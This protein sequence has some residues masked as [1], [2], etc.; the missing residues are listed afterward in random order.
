MDQSE[1]SLTL[2]HVCIGNCAIVNNTPQTTGKHTHSV[3]MIT[4]QLLQT[5]QNG[6][7]MGRGDTTVPE[8]LA[9]TTTSRKRRHVPHLTNS[10][11]L[12][13]SLQVG[14]DTIHC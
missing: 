6:V 10:Q 4:A 11:I 7:D 8:E 13:I 12:Y 3:S 9:L 5:T 1:L 14:L 2:W